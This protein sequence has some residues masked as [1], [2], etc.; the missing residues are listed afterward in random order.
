N[1][2]LIARELGVHRVTVK[3]RIRKM[4]EAGIILPPLCRF[5]NFFVPPGYL[6]VFSMIELKHSSSE[7]E[8]D[9]MEDPH[10]SVAYRISQGRYNLLLFEVHR[11]IEDYLTWESEYSKKYPLLFGSIMNN[12]LS[13]RMTIDID[14]QKVSL[15]AVEDRLAKLSDRGR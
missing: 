8:R 12:Y 14:Q 15:G 7:F 9:V 6:L 11:T 3:N 1:E 4:V 13:P 2:N 10:I 5:P